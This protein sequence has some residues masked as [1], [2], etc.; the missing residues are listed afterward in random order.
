MDYLY[1]GTFEGF[2]TCVYH[3]YYSGRA[4]GIYR[5]DVYQPNFLAEPRRVDSEEA[6][7]AR[8]S[9]AIAGRISGRDLERTYK[10]FLSSAADKEN[11]L[12]AY[13]VLGFRT[14]PDISRLHGNPV[15]FDVQQIEHKVNHEI[16]RFLGLI[17]FVSLGNGVLYSTFEPDHD[18][19]EFL[20]PHFSDRFRE[21]PF[22]LHDLSRDKA[23][24]SAGGQWYIC[25]FGPERIPAPEEG[26]AGIQKLWR[27]Y[28]H[29]IA[30]KERTNP[31]C[32]KAF[33][34]VRYWKH[35]TEMA[36][37]LPEPSSSIL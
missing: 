7:A 10:V 4:T 26:E 18:I 27:E 20:G 17:R 22:I 21:D 34:P 31:R 23:L 29:A 36:P 33:M 35:L 2:L 8:V 15:V 19:L 28:F 24:V 5:E 32:Q 16:H 6:L 1:D 3:H 12:L 14:G 30:I 11:R 13:L 9:R 25:P 37:D